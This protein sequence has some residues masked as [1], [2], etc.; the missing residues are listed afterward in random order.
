M[1]EAVVLLSGGLDSSTLL[2]VLLDEEFSVTALSVNYGQR[3]ACEL[4][5]ARLVAAQ[6]S[7]PIIELALGSVLA[8]IFARSTS[9][10]VGQ[11]TAVPEGHY[12]EPSMRTTIVPGRN[13]LLLSLAAALA[14]SEGA[15]VIAYA[16][17][18]G[19]H[20]IYADCRTDFIAE[21]GRTLRL[22]YDL[23]LYDPFQAMSKADIVRKGAALRV[24][25][26]LT[27]SCYNGGATH[28]GA[29]GTCFERREA[30]RDACVLDPT[31]YEG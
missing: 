27:Y 25:F 21:A 29:C 18:A 3:H 10:Q 28:C 9:S 6:A 30:F 15:S 8:P 19:D 26:E 12:A 11:K 5:A 7:V 16:A 23:T 31:R 4:E 2:H 17:H 20:S 13:L 1:R 22:G 14:Q 24:P